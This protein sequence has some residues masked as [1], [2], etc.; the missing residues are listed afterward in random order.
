MVKIETDQAYF[1]VIKAVSDAGI[2]VM[3]HIG[4]RPQT[5]T[6]MG[7]FKAEARGADMAEE[8]IRLADKMVEAGAHALLI[9]GVA[10]EVA[11]VI[12]ERVDVPVIGCGSGPGCDGQILIAPDILGI[13]TGQAPKFAKEFAHL[14]DDTIDAFKE[15]DAQVKKGRYPDSD[16]SYHMKKGEFEKLQQRLNQNL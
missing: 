6:K 7:R 16:H 4:I 8:L 13:S 12:T 10:A 9:E 3:A 5:I 2:A 15:Y 14:A 1:D 11:Q